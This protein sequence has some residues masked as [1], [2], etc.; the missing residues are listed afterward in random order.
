V[1]WLAALWWSLGTA[2]GG[3][4]PAGDYTSPSLRSD[5]NGDGVDDLAVGVL[6]ENN[7]A[8]GVNILYGQPGP[9]LSALGN[10]FFSQATP[11]VPAAPEPGDQCGAAL[12]AGDFDGDGVADLAL[13]CPGENTNAGAVILL[14]G[15]P[16]GG[17]TDLGSQFFSQNTPGIPGAEEPGD[18]CGAALAAGDFNGDGTD[19]LAV[20][21]FGEDLGSIDGAGE[22]TILYGA[23]GSGLTATG[24]QVFHQAT[25]SL[26]HTPDLAE[27]GDLCGAA[28]AAGDFDGDGVADLAIGCAN[29]D[30]GTVSNA[31]VVFILYGTGGSGLT[32]TGSQ[33]F[34]VSPSSFP[35]FATQ[36]GALCGAA[37]AA[38]D[39]SGD[40]IDDL[41]FGCPAWDRGFEDDVGA[42]ALLTGATGSGLAATDPHRFHEFGNDFFPSQDLK[43]GDQCGAALAT[44]DFNGDG[45]VDLAIGCPGDNIGNALTGNVV[46]NVGSVLIRRGCLVVASPIFTGLFFQ[47][48]PG[49][50]DGGEA[51]DLCGGALAAGDFNG[52]GVADLGFGCD[53]EDF[54]TLANSGAVNVLYGAA[55]SGLTATG[56]Q[57]FTQNTWGIADSAEAGD[58]FGVALAGAAG[59]TSP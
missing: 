30:I 2:V 43:E 8:G 55:G 28:L 31:G 49:V 42:V 35:V 22:V 48:T 50:P 3:V 39:F 16:G 59:H 6:G 23:A 12:A 24:S 33:V 37:L 27:A 29:E 57:V 58:L 14:Y 44:G 17:L 52:D 56:S 32:A 1:V 7:G 38:G 53:G 26:P 25:A 15:A 51:G 54:G 34:S 36:K 41:A 20:G 40:G 11:F 9:G 47:D 45:C 5:F 46:H 21:C 10:Q 4:G 18:R 13:G 19:D